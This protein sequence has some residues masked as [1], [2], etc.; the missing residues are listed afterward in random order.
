LATDPTIITGATANAIDIDNF[1]NFVGGTAS[2]T[3]NGASVSIPLQTIN[4]TLGDIEFSGTG[5]MNSTGTQI[6]INYSYDN[7]VPLIGGQ[8]SCMAIYDKQ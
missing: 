2:G 3:I 6:Q 8:G 5:T 1:F 7:M 4:I